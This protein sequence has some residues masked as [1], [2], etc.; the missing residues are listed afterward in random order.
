MRELNEDQ[1][2]AVEEALKEKSLVSAMA[3][4]SYS[5]PEHEIMEAV[6]ETWYERNPLHESVIEKVLDSMPG[7]PD[8]YCR[9]WGWLNF[10]RALEAEFAKSITAEKKSCPE[11]HDCKLIIGGGTSTLMGYPLGGRDPNR[12]TNEA[13]CKTHNTRWIR[14]KQLDDIRFERYER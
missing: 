7:G 3:L 14:Y 2:F 11:R 4:A 1:K 8:G 10:S 13:L 5:R 6:I 12:Y 9:S